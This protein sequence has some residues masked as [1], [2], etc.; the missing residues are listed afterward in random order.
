MKVSEGDRKPSICSLCK[1]KKVMI[2][3]SRL[4]S[5]YMLNLLFFS[6]SLSFSPS[7]S[8]FRLAQGQV[9]VPFSAAHPHHHAVCGTL[10]WTAQRK[11][12]VFKMSWAPSIGSDTT[13][14]A[15]GRQGREKERKKPSDMHHNGALC[16]LWYYSSTCLFGSFITSSVTSVFFGLLLL[17][18]SDGEG[19]AVGFC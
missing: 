13:Q 8:L 15:Q 16:Y 4:Q 7:R 1:L 11:A 10:W 12:D 18:D 17:G 19:T 3:G 6:L 5:T 2:Y 9:R 14:G